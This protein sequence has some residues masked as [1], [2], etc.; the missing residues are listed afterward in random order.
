ML[1]VALMR[2]GLWISFKIS[3]AHISW[4]YKVERNGHSLKKVKEARVTSLQHRAERE[5]STLLQARC[6][7]VFL[8]TS[9]RDRSA[10]ARCSSKARRKHT[11]ITLG[12]LQH[13]NELIKNPNPAVLGHPALTHS[14][15]LA[16]VGSHH[17]G[18]ASRVVHGIDVGPHTQNQE[19]PRDILCY[20][21]SVEWSSA[22]SMC[23][24]RNQARCWIKKFPYTLSM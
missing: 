17:E 22:H 13:W 5:D 21:G 2:I 8:F 19:Q 3:M 18:R 1:L 15:A 9:R 16:L 12:L 23:Y 6:R 11:W 10:L 14:A 4:A 24:K 7:A 20:G